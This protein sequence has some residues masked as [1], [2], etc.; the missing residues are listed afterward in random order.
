MNNVTSL[1]LCSS[2]FYECEL[3]YTSFGDIEC[4]I[5]YIRLVLLVNLLVYQQIRIASR[6]PLR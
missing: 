1:L 4:V 2:L 5:V 6:W 3:H